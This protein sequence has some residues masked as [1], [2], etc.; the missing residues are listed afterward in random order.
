MKATPAKLKD[1]SWGARI[2][3]ESVEIGDSVTITTR[4]GKSWDAT[5]SRVLWHRDGVSLV[6]TKSAPRSS[7]GNRSHSHSTGNAEPGCS[8]CRYIPGV[9]TAQIWEDCEYCGAEPIY[10]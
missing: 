10:M 5:V 8:H 7:S 3:S 1:G 2:K 9:R 4:N 6:A